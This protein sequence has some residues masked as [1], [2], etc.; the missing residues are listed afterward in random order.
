MK[1]GASITDIGSIKF[2]EDTTFG[3][4]SGYSGIQNNIGSFYDVGSDFLDTLGS[5]YNT[6]QNMVKPFS[7][8]VADKKD[9]F[10]MTLPTTLH[11][12]ID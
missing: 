9:Y 1:L 2:M 8:V 5:P 11:V 3:N 10:R 12:N 6:A 7:T 4:L